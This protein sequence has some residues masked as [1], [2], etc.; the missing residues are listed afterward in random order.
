MNRTSEVERLIEQECKSEEIIILKKDTTYE[1]FFLIRDE[2]IKLN[3]Y[4]FSKY[5]K[6]NAD[7]VYP[8]LLLYYYTMKKRKVQGFSS[9]KLLEVKL[10]QLTVRTVGIINH[11]EHCKNSSEKL[12]TDE[13]LIDLFGKAFMEEARA[14]GLFDKI[15]RMT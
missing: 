14:R 2:V 4:K 10:P 6:D 5:F 12:P 15:D 13:E 7:K 11:L 9:Y 1:A 3:H 8:P